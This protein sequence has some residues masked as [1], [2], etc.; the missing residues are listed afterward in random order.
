MIC[1]ENPC[2]S[3]SASLAILVNRKNF[4]DI[5]PSIEHTYD[6]RPIIVQT[7]KYDLRSGGE[8]AQTGP[9]FVPRTPR[10]RE[11]IDT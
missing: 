5:L 2:H 8:R 11:L 4:L 6:F 9:N 10:G 7:I 1:L 3:A